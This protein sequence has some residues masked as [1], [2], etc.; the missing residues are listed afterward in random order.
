MGSFPIDEKQFIDAGK[1]EIHDDK[2]QKP[3]IYNEYLPFHQLIKQQ[4]F[5]LFNE[6]REHLSQA[7]QLAELEPGFSF[8]SNKLEQFISLYGFYFTKNDH[9]KLIQFY[10]SIL[11]INNLNYS[12]VKICFDMLAEL[13]KFVFFF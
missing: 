10:L 7:I 6:I 5:E 12:N 1:L 8:W 4:G 11:S 9:L 13:M 2:L 3:N